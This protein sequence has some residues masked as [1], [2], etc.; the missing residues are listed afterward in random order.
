M[1][2]SIVQGLAGEEGRHESV[3]GHHVAHTG[4]KLH[5]KVLEV[6]GEDSV[7]T[8]VRA[9]EG[10]LHSGVYVRAAV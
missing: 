9:G 2:V 10:W 6:A 3:S 5:G 7:G 8:L 1:G 4:G